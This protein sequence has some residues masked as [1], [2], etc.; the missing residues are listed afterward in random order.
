[1]KKEKRKAENI[2]PD[3]RGWQF[4]RIMQFPVMQHEFSKSLLALSL[5]NEGFNRSNEGTKISR[6]IFVEALIH[7][8]SRSYFK[9][10]PIGTKSN[11]PVFYS[12][13]IANNLEKYIDSINN[14]ITMNEKDGL[15]IKKLE[16]GPKNKPFFVDISKSPFRPYA[17][18]ALFKKEML[19]FNPGFLKKYPNYANTERN[20]YWNSYFRIY[21]SMMAKVLP[22]VKDLEHLKMIL[23]KNFEDAEMGHYFLT[24]FSDVML[25]PPRKTF[26]Y[27]ILKKFKLSSKQCLL[28]SEEN[29]KNEFKAWLESSK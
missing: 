1:M 21:C 5:S 3:K 7:P 25:E 6:E 17:F 12:P 24:L 16:L 13:S 29:Q 10:I 26:G 28:E 18:T 9:K 11:K 23:L 19:K 4:R 14:K 20:I 22:L 15:L 8:L 2:V 27:S